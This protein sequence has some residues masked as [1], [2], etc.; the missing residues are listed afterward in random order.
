MILVVSVALASCGQGGATGSRLDPVAARDAIAVQSCELGGADYTSV[1]IYVST[2]ATDVAYEV[3][4]EVRLLN[5]KHAAPETHRVSFVVE[6]DTTHVY[7][8][9]GMDKGA[10]EYMGCKVEV[11]DVT[12]I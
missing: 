8:Q 4:A 9:P 7:V 10:A 12:T 3:E 5:P 6:P 11:L 2:D 1:T